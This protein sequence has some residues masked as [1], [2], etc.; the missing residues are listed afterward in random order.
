[1]KNDHQTED[2]SGQA[3]R[4]IRAQAFGLELL[5]RGLAPKQVA[6]ASGISPWK[7]NQLR[8]G[9]RPNDTAGRTPP[10]ASTLLREPD[11]RIAASL[12]VDV[13]WRLVDDRSAQE[14]DWDLFLSSYD[15]Y[16]AIAGSI[17]PQ[18]ILSI[19][20]ACTIF[21]AFMSGLIESRHCTQHGSR[22]LVIA[23]R[24]RSWGCPYCTLDSGEWALDD[25]GDDADCPGL[26]QQ[27][28]R[29]AGAED[30]ETAPTMA[31]KG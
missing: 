13:Y 3:V 2:S 22:Y 7:A 29:I 17:A 9:L 31:V 1:M 4:T 27:L 16:E 28:L 30:F 23:E 21:I 19:V 8:Q 18:N 26:P 10:S 25:E 6:I 11:S 14:A 15:I 5:E 24:C 12:F 20:N